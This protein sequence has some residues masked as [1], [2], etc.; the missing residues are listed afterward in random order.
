MAHELNEEEI[1]QII[2]K[3]K[4][5]EPEKVLE[6]EDIDDFTEYNW[7]IRHYEVIYG[8]VQETIMKEKEE[9]Y[10]NIIIRTIAITPRTRE[11]VM[12]VIEN[13]DREEWKQTY[14][15]V[16]LPEKGWIKVK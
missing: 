10:G 2:E 4:N 7:F 6:F 3:A 12:K 5:S 13:S 11:V 1:R 15:Y 8:E 16:F 9:C 14:F